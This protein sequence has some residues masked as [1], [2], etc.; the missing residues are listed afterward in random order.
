[1][2]NTEDKAE[3]SGAEASNLPKTVAFQD[4]FTR[5]FMDST[6]EVEDG[7]Y[8]FKSKTGGYTMLF[9][10]HAKI[11]TFGFEQSG[12]EL[13]T[14]SF[15]EVRNE[16]N[17]S[18][19]WKVLYENMPRTRDVESNLAFLSD[20]YGYKGD[21]TQFKQ[22]GKTYYYAKKVKNIEGK[23]VNTFLYLIK[24]DSDDKAIS[25]SMKYICT[26]SKKPC[27][28]DQQTMEAEAER[29]IK[30]IKFLD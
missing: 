12:D 14:F 7:Y 10:K 28:V 25:Y 2:N 30:S 19:K 9:P 11:A 24:N 23:E 13:E 3:K 29:L 18:L 8:L 20:S 16:E 5:G 22:E 1:M 17:I 15:G 27:K 6:K 4:E 26:D 21:Y